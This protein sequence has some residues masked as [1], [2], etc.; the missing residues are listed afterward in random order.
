MYFPLEERIE[1]LKAWYKR[2]NERP[3]VGFFIDSQYPLHRY[4][5]MI[6][7]KKPL[8]IW[9]NL[10]D[11]DLDYIR[12]ELPDKGLSVIPFVKDK[13]HANRILAKFNIRTKR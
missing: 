8:I 9:G 6:L 10:T 13:F 5:N 4:H 3:Q 1:R 12:N 11:D 7:E 2:E